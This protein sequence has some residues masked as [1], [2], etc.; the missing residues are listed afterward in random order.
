MTGTIASAATAKVVQRIAVEGGPLDGAQVLTQ[1]IAADLAEK[2]NAVRYPA[3]Y[4]YCE[5]IAN[6]LAEKFRTFSGTVQMA[7]ELRHSCDRAE[8]LQDWL[9]SGADGIAHILGLSRGD[10]GD[11]M[12]YS[13]GYQVAFGP[14]KHGGRNFIQTAKLTFEIG[15]SIS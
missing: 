1:N 5:K 14:A 13:G 8:K 6:S 12:Y 2:S 3:A 15:V 9:E 11:G 10:W 4:V 7:I